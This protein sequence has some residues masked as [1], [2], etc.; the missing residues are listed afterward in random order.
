MSIDSCLCGTISLACFYSS[1]RY[2]PLG[3][4]TTIRFTSPV[5]IA[6][7]A[8]F[9]V[10]EP[11]GL[12]Q[13][14][15]A[16][17][18]LTGVLLIGRPSFIFGTSS[19][20][21]NT[22]KSITEVDNVIFLRDVPNTPMNESNLITDS[23]NITELFVSQEFVDNNSSMLPF[24]AYLKFKSNST[25]ETIPLLYLTPLAISQNV[26]DLPKSDPFSTASILGVL[27]SL[28]A[29]ISIS[30][31]MIFMRKLKKTPAPLVIFWFSLSN[32]LVGTIGMAIL[33][34]FHLPN[35]FFSWLLIFLT[36]E[37]RK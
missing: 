29:A 35:E 22:A 25:D 28:A 15:N 26:D 5:F 7:F 1:Y 2:I 6:I 36:S 4:A 30:I 16:F 14:V 32:V 12:L 31:S 37:Y 21:L 33:G 18:T 13:L 23:V 8:H 20:P 10:N 9:L 34:E 19:Q 3:D 17:T 27:L 24:L 11:F